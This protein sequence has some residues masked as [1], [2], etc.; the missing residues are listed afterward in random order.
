M[1]PRLLHENFKVI[2]LPDPDADTKEILR[3]VEVTF[4]P[5]GF[6]CGKKKIDACPRLRAIASNTTGD[7]HIDVPYAESRKIAV[8]TLRDEREFLCTITATAEHTWGLILALVR[9]IP[10]AFDSVKQG[11]WNRRLF[12]GKAMLSTMSLGIVG[13]GRLGT[14]VAKYGLNFGMQVRYYDPYVDPPDPDTVER[15]DTLETLVSKSDI[16]SVHVPHNEETESMFHSEVFEKFK[17]GSYLINTARAE[18]VDSRALLKA[19]QSGR[20]AGAALDVFEGEFGKNFSGSRSFREHSLLEYAR[21]HDNLLLSPHI[22]GS[23]VD[24]WEKTERF[25][26]L[27]VMA[28]FAESN[29]SVQTES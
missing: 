12:P 28:C 18:V 6:Y 29:M 26:I 5:L 21:T 8:I 3:D 16:I 15:V 9:R 14:M 22:G 4:A 10:W 13:L 24:A 11:T 2:T 19:L 20:L 7:P 23:T 27:K 1:Q 25:T 17:D